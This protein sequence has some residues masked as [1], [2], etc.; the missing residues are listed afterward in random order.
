VTA[1]ASTLAAYLRDERTIWDDRWSNRY[2]PSF[3][4]W[5]TTGDWVR[6]A[7]RLTGGDW[8]DPAAILVLVVGNPRG[9]EK[10][11]YLLQRTEPHHEVSFAEGAHNVVIGNRD[12]GSLRRTEADAEHQVIF[13]PERDATMW[14]SSRLFSQQSSPSRCRQKTRMQQRLPVLALLCGLTL[15]MHARAATAGTFNQIHFTII[16]GN[17][18]LRHDSS[19]IATIKATDG[20]SQVITLKGHN[21]GKWGN[22]STDN[23]TAALNPPLDPTHISQ[24]VVT[25]QQ[26]KGAFEGDDNWNIESVRISL[27]NGGKNPTEFM[28][29]YGVPLVRLTG[30]QGSFALP[31]AFPGPKGTFNQIQFIIG[32]GSDDLRGNSSADVT[33]LSPNGNTLQTF[34][35]KTEHQSESWPNNST[36]TVSALL[37]PPNRLCE[38]GHI[39]LTLHSHNHGVETDDNWNVESV[40]VSLSDNGGPATRWLNIAGDPVARLTGSLGTMVLDNPECHTNVLGLQTSGRLKGFVDLHTHPLANLGFGGK[41]FYGGVDVGSLLRVDPDG[42]QNVRATSM[43]QALGHCNCVHGGWGLDNKCGDDIRAKVIHTQ[44]QQNQPSVDPSDNARGAPDFNEWPVWN[45]SLHQKMWVEWIRR[46]Y[47]GGLRVMVALAVNNRTLSQMAAG[48]GDSAADDKSSADLQI[49]E[50]KSF[51]QRHAD[52][53]EIALSSADLER[54]VRKNKL[55][56]VLGIE[57]DNPGNLNKVSRLTHAQVATEID[58]LFHEGVR[59]IFPIHLLDNPFGG[60]AAYQDLMNYSTFLESGHWWSLEAVTDSK[61]IFQP[62]SG[63]PFEAAVMA[64]LHPAV[65]G[66]ILVGGAAGGLAGGAAGGAVGG[67]AGAAAGAGAVADIAAGATK[68]LHPPSYPVL[69]DKNGK[70]TGGQINKRPLTDNGTFAIKTMMRHGMLIDIDHMSRLAKDQTLKIGADNQYPINSGHNSVTNPPGSGT[71]RNMTDHEYQKLSKLHGMV[72]VGTVGYNAHDWAGNCEDIVTAIAKDPSAPKTMILALGTDTDGLQPGM[73]PRGNLMN[74]SGTPLVRLTGRAPSTLLHADQSANTFIG[75][76]NTIQFMIMTGGDDLRGDSTA[77]AKLLSSVTSTMTLQVI[78]LKT[79]KQGSWGNYSNHT[80]TAHLN[81]P[82]HL[83]DIGNIVITLE[84]GGKITETADNWNVQ[85]VAVSLSHQGKG[86]IIE[87]SD[88]FPRSSLGTKF[89]DYNTDGVAHY[90]MLPEF[91]RDVKSA[92]NGTNLV[93]NNLIFGADYFLQTWKLCEA[94]KANIK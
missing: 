89:W 57:I 25:L 10:A 74:K 61:Y 32:T 79:N 11:R 80:V 77:V 53:M 52:F 43:E 73:P 46:S 90:G 33:L 81:P 1:A 18:D 41:V 65:L 50:I 84:Q 47:D 36:H 39:E 69:K 16:T 63:L 93:E 21:K 37:K 51:V 49:A 3:D 22:Y 23:V 12:A 17:D 62:E 35:I 87:Y 14:R 64:R 13:N 94:Q 48:S 55:A 85:F 5:A 6:L 24:I 7:E 78:T 2:D 54:I 15:F 60:T 19:A 83:G 38:I 68:V 4:T 40:H 59:Y 72:G 58:R 28:S 70:P 71:E 45:E 75:P 9:T 91:F 76:F 44:N 42:H 92:P 67:G 86:A 66:E 88:A 82:L 30:S 20:K 27:S 31:S 8:P 34:T 26:H 29:F 56:I